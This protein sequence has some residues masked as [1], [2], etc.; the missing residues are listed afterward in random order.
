MPPMIAAFG[1][2]ELRVT[3]EDGKAR[4]GVIG[5]NIRVRRRLC[6]SGSRRW[7]YQKDALNE[8]LRSEG[9]RRPDYSC[10]CQK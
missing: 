5:A 10:R 7:G 3:S 9:G 6:V 1:P 8:D 2:V 4:L